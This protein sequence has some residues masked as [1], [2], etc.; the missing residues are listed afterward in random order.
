MAK[1]AN[2]TTVITFRFT[3]PLYT[4]ST[5]KASS[6]ATSSHS[7]MIFWFLFKDCCCVY[8]HKNRCGNCH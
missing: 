8:E 1:N 2:S 7:R 6:R 4:K 5:N 3:A